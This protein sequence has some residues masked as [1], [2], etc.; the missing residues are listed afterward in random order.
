M[1]FHQGFNV[2]LSEYTFTVCCQLWIM[3]WA[4]QKENFNVTCLSIHPSIYITN[5]NICNLSFSFPA[6]Y[7]MDGYERMDISS[8]VYTKWVVKFGVASLEA[9]SVVFSLPSFASRSLTIC[10]S[11]VENKTLASF[12]KANHCVNLLRVEIFWTLWPDEPTFPLCRVTVLFRNS[13]V[14]STTKLLTALNSYIVQN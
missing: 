12:G 11:E 3:C 2:Y 1:I 10:A 7:L 6:L 5:I 9:G 4:C 13:P 8:F 14:A